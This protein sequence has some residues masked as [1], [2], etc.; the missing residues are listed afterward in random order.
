MTPNYFLPDVYTIACVPALVDYLG[1]EC[2]HSSGLSVHA[3]LPGLFSIW[4]SKIMEELNST[5]YWNLSADISSHIK[6]WYNILCSAFSV[7]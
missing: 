1:L 3:P 2:L 5:I 6:Q 7:R 4:G